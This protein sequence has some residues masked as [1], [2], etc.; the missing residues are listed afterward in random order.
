MQVRF[1]VCF[2]LVLSF[3][4]EMLSDIPAFVND[5]VCFGCFVLVLFCFQKLS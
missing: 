3:E 4:T 2:I 1:S 5:K